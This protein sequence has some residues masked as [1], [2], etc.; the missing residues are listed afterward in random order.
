MNQTY[1]VKDYSTASFQC[2]GTGIPAPNINWYRNES[3]I[4]ASDRFTMS[5]STYL[6]DSTLVYVV[7]SAL[8]ITQAVESDSGNYTCSANNTVDNVAEQFE[9]DVLSEWIIHIMY[10]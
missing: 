2:I 7:I 3:L 5:T 1:T 9:L 8:N 4:I 10:N 6:N